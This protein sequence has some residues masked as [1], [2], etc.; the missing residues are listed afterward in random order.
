LSFHSVLTRQVIENSKK[1]EKKS[2]NQKIPLWLH[3]KPKSVGKGRG[4]EKIKI[5][6]PFPSHSTRNRK[7]QKISKKM[8]KMIKIHY[9][10]IS[11]QN[12]LEK[13]NE[14]RK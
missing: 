13:A 10:V 2:K 8:K 9:G 3:S 1:K 11:S 14:E 5:A 12:R 7:F 4:I 6:V